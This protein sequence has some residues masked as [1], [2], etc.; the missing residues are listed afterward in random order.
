M[1]ILPSKVIQQMSVCENKRW[2]VLKFKSKNY[3]EDFTKIHAQYYETIKINSNDKRIPQ[4]AE[5][6]IKY[7][8]KATDAEKKT[9]DFFNYLKTKYLTTGSSSAPR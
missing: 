2:N 1:Y 3:S 5:R 7:E 6:V 8:I 4:M 9:I